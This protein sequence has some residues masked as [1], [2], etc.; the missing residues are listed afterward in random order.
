MTSLLLRTIAVISNI[1]AIGREEY[2]RRIEP[3]IIV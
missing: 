2:D 3:V 1:S